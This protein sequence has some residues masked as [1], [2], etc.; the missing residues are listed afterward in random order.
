MNNRL[1]LNYFFL[2]KKIGEDTENVNAY[3]E[4]VIKLLGLNAWSLC[5]VLLTTE[6]K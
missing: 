6:S 4:S 3:K 5:V 1:T 2:N